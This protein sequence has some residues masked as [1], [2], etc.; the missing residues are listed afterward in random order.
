[1][2]RQRRPHPSFLARVGCF[3]VPALLS[4][5]AVL[6]ACKAQP[7]ASGSGNGNAAPAAPARPPGEAVYYRSCVRCHGANM[8][9]DGTAP[10]LTRAR[11]A[12]LGDQPM[13]MTIVYGKGQ[14]PGFGGLSDAQVAAV[15]AYMRGL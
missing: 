5:A 11:I 4:L 8:E 14:M 13:E 2:P 15:I 9:G 12:S 3:A 6:G 1:M 10:A 7:S